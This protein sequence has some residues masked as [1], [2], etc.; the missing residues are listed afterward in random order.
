MST[1]TFKIAINRLKFIVKP[2]QGMIDWDK[3]NDGFRNM[4]LDILRFCNAI[5]MG[6]P[7]CP[8]MEGRRKVEN[9]QLAQHIAIDMDCADG[10][11]DMETLQRHPLVQTYGAIIHETPSHRPEAPRS[12]VI[13]ILDE[14][15]QDAN[16]YKVA[17]QTVTDLF[18]GSDPACV[19]SA[20]FFYGNGGLHMTGRTEGIWFNPEACLPLAELRRFARIRMAKQRE[21]EQ[22]NRTQ[23]VQKATPS[24]NSREPPGRG[25]QMTLNEL[26]ERLGHVNPYAMGYE[27]WLKLIAAIRHCYGDAAFGVV[28][29]WSDIPKEEP[30]TESKWNSLKDSHPNPAGYGTI[31]QI[32]QELGR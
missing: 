4:E 8:W 15:I 12:R 25:D 32:V 9:F 5:Y 6:F 28:K 27:T 22:Q 14:P 24:G 20:R 23:W 10:R 17:I 13:F 7:Y 1:D 31:V 26:R 19:D 29:A 3:F 16:G 18:D 30:L 11:A 2:T 21:L